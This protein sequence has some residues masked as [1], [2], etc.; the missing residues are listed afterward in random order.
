MAEN[1]HTN[2][3]TPFFSAVAAFGISSGAAADIFFARQPNL[4]RHPNTS[5]LPASF[6]ELIPTMPVDLTD[7]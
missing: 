6:Y 7:E 1:P 3:C 5:E 2:K 4:S